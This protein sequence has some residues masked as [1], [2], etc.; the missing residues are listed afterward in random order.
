MIRFENLIQELRSYAQKI[1]A[2][3]GNRF[4]ADELI[5]EAWIRGRNSNLIA[6]K[7]IRQRA[8]WDMKDYIRSEVGRVVRKSVK[9]KLITNLDT[10]KDEDNHVTND[11][12]DGGVEDKSLLEL[13]DKE[14]LIKLLIENTTP[15]QFKAMFYYYFEEKT[16]KETG[17]IL[18]KKEV[19]IHGLVKKGIKK[20]NYG[21]E[22]MSVR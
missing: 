21:L 3:W 19:T 1:A 6:V 4:V 20:C 17:K 7:D 5:N 9:P 8:I 16:L 15:K 14:L 18:G 11:I 22:L 13:E 10:F 2:N 12:L